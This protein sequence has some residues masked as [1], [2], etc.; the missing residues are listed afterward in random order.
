MNQ[1]KLPELPYD[2]NAL[3]PHISAKIMEL[4]HGK[5][6]A[7][8]AECRRAED[9][10]ELC[11]QD[12]R[13]IQADPHSALAKERIVFPR[14]RQIGQWLVAA[15]I[16]RPDDERLARTERFNDRFVS[17][18]LLLF[19]WRIGPTHEQE[20]R[21]QQADAF[22]AERRD[23]SG[24]FEAPYVG[25]NLDAPSVERNRRFDCVSEVVAASVRRLLLRT[26]NAREFLG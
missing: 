26:A 25:E 4:H 15:H 12:L 9:R 20:F 13:T 16:E 1:Y 14:N 18:K 24:V 19:G 17:G 8:L 6:H 10:P 5:H 11:A 23:P 3:E 7:D 21:T 2:Y 22:G